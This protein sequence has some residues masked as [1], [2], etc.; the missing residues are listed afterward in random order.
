MARP[1]TRLD[2]AAPSPGAAAAVPAAGMT[3][4]PALSPGRCSGL[5]R[6]HSPREATRPRSI[7]SRSDYSGPHEAESRKDYPALHTQ[8][9]IQDTLVACAAI[10]LR[11][12][13]YARS[14]QRRIV[15][16]TGL[17]C[18]PPSL[19]CPV[20]G[21]SNLAAALPNALAATNG[22][23]FRNRY[24]SVLNLQTAPGTGAMPCGGCRK[25]VRTSESLHQAR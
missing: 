1:W 3:L 7:D 12:D 6:R 10:P 20:R 2:L 14:F 15:A 21:G 16:K 19:I 4:A 9:N 11:G 22:C 17:P 23:A 13:E 8:R 18:N 24:A 25:W 5:P